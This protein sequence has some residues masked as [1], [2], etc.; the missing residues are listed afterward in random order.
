MVSR[1]LRA[2]LCFA[3][4]VTVAYAPAVAAEKD[5]SVSVDIQGPNGG[6]LSLSFPAEI[7]SGFL[8][9]LG[10]GL[11]CDAE[12]DGE[13]REMLEHLD[14][15]GERSKYEI[16]GD[17]GEV[18]KARRRR[19]QLELDILRPDE[20]KAHVSMPWAIAE[21]FLGRDVEILSAAGI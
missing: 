16:E 5:R 12:P 1:I 13:W 3:L 10:G 14:R 8:E 11:R 9:G 6:S 4:L 18:I 2:T 7:V 15:R 17:D 21:C 20:P 19:G